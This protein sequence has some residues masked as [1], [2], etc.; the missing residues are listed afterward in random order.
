MVLQMKTTAFPTIRSESKDFDR[1]GIGDNSDDDIDGDGLS[2]LREFALGTDPYDI[3]T[4]GDG[5]LD[6]K[7]LF[8]LDPNERFDL[9]DDG[10]GDQ[11]D[12]CPVIQS[13]TN[14]H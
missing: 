4:D 14:R 6:N 11:S 2:N 7:D 5:A 8:P 12:N 3:D 10:I 9:D 13:V 1:D